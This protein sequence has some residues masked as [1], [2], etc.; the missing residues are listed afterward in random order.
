MGGVL[1]E[2]ARVRRDHCLFGKPADGIAPQTVPA[3]VRA[4]ILRGHGGFPDCPVRSPWG[5]AND[6]VSGVQRVAPSV[7]PH[8]GGSPMDRIECRVRR[9][10]MVAGLDGQPLESRRSP[11]T[12]SPVVAAAQCLMDLCV[13]IRRRGVEAGAARATEMEQAVIVDEGVMAADGDPVAPLIGRARGPVPWGRDRS[14]P[15]V[16]Q[17]DVDVRGWTAMRVGHRLGDL[18][19]RGWTALEKVTGQRKA[20]AFGDIPSIGHVR[21]PTSRGRGDRVSPRF[22]RGGLLVLPTL[23]EIRPVGRG[24]E[25]VE[26]GPQVRRYRSDERVELGSQVRRDQ[27]EVVVR[28]VEAVER[29]HLIPVIPVRHAHRGDHVR[30]CPSRLGRPVDPPVPGQGKRP[31]AVLDPL[32]P[33]PPPVPRPGNGLFVVRIEGQ[34]LGRRGPVAKLA[35]QGRRVT[36]SWH[37]ASFLRVR[38]ARTGRRPGAPS[39]DRGRG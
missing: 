19:A 28:P 18:A 6:P 10:L 27:P 5:T 22:S 35:W 4:E 26:I 1:G 25:P 12:A 37:H 20:D 15:S 16:P 2:L 39:R 29:M 3:R 24:H 8:V 9:D 21:H 11:T 33:L 14:I 30:Q 34:F 36:V 31:G 38:A 17:G 23:R 13:E 7:V 32:H